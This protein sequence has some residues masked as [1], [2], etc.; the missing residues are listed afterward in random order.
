MRSI[1]KLISLFTPGEKRRLIPLTLAVVVMSFLEVA[2]IGALGPFM[3]VVAD[4]NIIRTQP[5]LSSLY[6]FFGFTDDRAFLIAMGVGIFLFMVLSTVFK[7]FVLYAMY[8]YVGNRRYTL[9]HRLFKQYLY[10]PYS[11]FLDHN[12]SELSKNLLTEVD[13]VVS[14][15]LRPTMDAFARGVLALSILGFLIASNPVVALAT[16]AIFGVFYLTMYGF[17]RPRLAY[18]GKNLREANRVRFK[19]AGE[20]FGAIKDVKILGKEPAFSQTYA[21]GARHFALSQASRQIFSTLPGQ[22]MY[23][24]AAGFAVA[25]VIFLLGTHGSLGEMLPLLA[26]YAF[27][28]QRLIPE[29]KDIFQAAS[30]IRYYRHTVDVL[31]SDM[32]ETHPPVLPETEELNPPSD[33]LPFNREVQLEKLAFSYPTSRAPVLNEIDLTINKNT[34]IGLVGTT[35]CG[36]TTLVDVI[37]LLL[38]PTGGKMLV[39]GN[40]ITDKVKWQRNFGYV[41]QQIFLSD[42]TVAANIAFGVPE[43]LRNPA[44]VEQAAKVANLHDFVT[45]ELEHGYDTLVGERGIRLSGGQRQRVGIARALYHDPDI[46][47]MDE[48]TSALDSVTE[49]AVMDAIHN[50]M[51]TKTIM[52][53]AHRITTVRECD[54]IFFLERGRIIARGKYDALVRDNPKF[55]A[56]AKVNIE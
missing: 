28:L 27:A 21:A 51:H 23:P 16:G 46:L 25:L 33:R 34:T 6:Q 53:I 40:P 14:D 52:I 50:L 56:M 42:D 55:R 43:R 22:T 8:R 20:A 26:V 31:Y 24:L 29:I 47:V 48:A 35:G 54:E 12:T 45:T 49:D 4:P 3:S 17:V 11:Y 41:P 18:H 19:A 7:M 15:V 1:I 13:L 30:Q 2:G 44:A 36:K 10:Q 37:M 39:D 38:E 9:S 32:T 5:I